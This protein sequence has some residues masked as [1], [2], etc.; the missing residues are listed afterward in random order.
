[1]PTKKSPAP[2]HQKSKPSQNGKLDDLRI[3]YVPLDDILLWDHN[4]KLHDIGALIESIWRYG[5]VDEPKYDATLGAIVFGNGRLLALAQGRQAGREPPRGIKQA[6][7]K[8]WLV[9]IK[10]GVDQPSQAEA[11]AL[12]IDHNNLT[13][14]GGDFTAIDM[15][16]AWNSN[17]AA[18]LNNLAQGDTF[19]VTV[20]A[21]ALAALAAVA[22]R[23]L[24]PVEFTEFGEDIT[25]D[26]VCPKCGY[27]WSGGE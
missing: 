14:A 16:R 9:P 23:D 3:E 2:K 24:P 18:L 13:M 22:R 17:Y 19:T 12:G 21:E 20:N 1:M 10:F 5:F 25:V 15:S 4:P 8:T 27:K 7:D 26:H 6:K 11:E